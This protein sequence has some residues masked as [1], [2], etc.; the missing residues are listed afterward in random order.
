MLNKLIC[1]ALLLAMGWLIAEALVV[2]ADK[3]AEYRE[4]NKVERRVQDCGE[5]YRREYEAV[6]A[7]IGK[8]NGYCIVHEPD[9]TMKVLPVKEAF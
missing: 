1:A 7:R 9:C 4:R 3:E 2:A 8:M 6:L 5:E